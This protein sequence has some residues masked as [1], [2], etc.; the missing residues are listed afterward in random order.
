M[1]NGPSNKRAL[2]RGRK[3]TSWGGG[4]TR[5]CEKNSAWAGKK[6]SGGGGQVNTGKWGFPE[7]VGYKEHGNA[8]VQKGKGGLCKGERVT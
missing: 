7:L 5:K 4:R 2:C 1:F 8:P 3:K 6:G